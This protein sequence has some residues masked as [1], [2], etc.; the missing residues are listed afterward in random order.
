MIK[1][2][3]M[4]IEKQ[5]NIALIAHDGKKQDMLKW[6]MDNKEIL[7]QAR[8]PQNDCG[9]FR[10]RVKADDGCCVP[11]FLLLCIINVGTYSRILVSLYLS[12]SSSTNLSTSMIESMPRIKISETSSKSCFLES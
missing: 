2:L 12:I 3:T 8:L 4:T 10:R 11:R 5:K 9:D 1:Y 6:C 7:Q